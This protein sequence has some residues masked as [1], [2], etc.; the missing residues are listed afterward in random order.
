MLRIVKRTGNIALWIGGKT[1]TMNG[2]LTLP[3]KSDC[4]RWE[5]L[6]RCL[7]IDIRWSIRQGTEILDK[8]EKR[9]TEDGNQEWAKVFR[10]IKD[11]NLMGALI[12]IQKGVWEQEKE[13]EYRVPV[14]SSEAVYGLFGRGGIDRN[15]NKE[16]GYRRVELEQG[17]DDTDNPTHK[18]KEEHRH[19]RERDG[20]AKLALTVGGWQKTKD[21]IN[22]T[23][24]GG[25]MLVDTKSPDGDAVQVVSLPDE[26][27]CLVPYRGKE[28]KDKALLVRDRLDTGPLTGDEIEILREALNA[29]SHCVDGAL[30]YVGFEAFISS[31]QRHRRQ[32][33]P[34]NKA[35][36]EREFIV[37]RLFD[38]LLTR[39]WEFVSLFI[40][41][42]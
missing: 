26:I 18:A 1:E 28:L 21:I 5:G 34:I 17:Y 7:E 27:V 40:P 16:R 32:T 11:Y 42:E 2:L 31:I 30:D 13:N 15:G 23:A 25:G 6:E 12:S 36:R 29:L 39:A 10:Y 24:P 8:T 37:G 22:A 4:V 41:F 35:D 9:V 3:I 38:T 20:F 19:S 33:Q 14:R